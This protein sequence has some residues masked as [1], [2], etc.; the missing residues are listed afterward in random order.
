MPETA[1]STEKLRQLKAV[2]K[3]G[4]CYVFSAVICLTGLLVNYLRPLNARP[5][6]W[7]DD[8]LYFR[9]AIALTDGEWLG[10]LDPV[11]LSKAP[12]FALFLAGTHELGIPLRV[13]EW[14]LMVAGVYLWAMA[15]RPLISNGGVSALLGAL[16]LMF[17]PSVGT[18]LALV[19]NTFF[20]TLVVFTLIC[21]TGFL[22]RT[23]TGGGGR[24]WL[25]GAAFFVGLCSIT[26]EEAGW[27]Y[28]PIAT[29]LILSLRKLPARQWTGAVAT[30]VLAFAAMKL[31][32]HLVSYMN[33]RAYGIHAVSL[34]Q[35]ASFKRLYQALVSSGERGGI[36]YVPV[37]E[38]VRVRIYGVSPTFAQLRPFLEGEPTD[39]IAKNRGHH[40]LNRVEN[41]NREFFVSNFEFALARSI[42]LAGHEDGAAIHQFCRQAADEIEAGQRSGKLNAGGLIA[43]MIGPFELNDAS[44]IFAALMKS[45]S[46]LVGGRQITMDGVPSFDP[47]AGDLTNWYA[48]T[49][50]WPHV[51]SER[52]SLARSLF[53]RWCKVS[54]IFY[55]A[56]FLLGLTA[57]GLGIGNKHPGSYTYAA[58]LL[59]GLSALVA[60]SLTMGVADTLAFPVL[61]WPMG[62]NRMGFFCLHFLL[63][64]AS[65]G[66]PQILSH[67]RIAV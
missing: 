33:N 56:I 57:A 21:L 62:Y 23:R 12:G 47:Y 32:T 28:L 59:V 26:R 48:F 14:L 8:A 19:R 13:A 16:A 58:L 49:R 40:Q 10:K 64:V 41:L 27:L 20:G 6:Q 53:Q 45:L 3:S 18:E 36:R 25:V 17:V 29:A 65:T 35:D 2:L 31:P 61:Q 60:F 55:C 51:N 39:D 15:I 43:P 50:T 30:A 34:R 46:M 54:G 44:T 37:S 42:W 11:L 22:V 4:P 66:L 1:F 7:A 52:T 5:G 67:R 38:A 9:Q 63:L 24:I